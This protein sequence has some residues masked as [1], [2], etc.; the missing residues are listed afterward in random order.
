MYLNDMLTSEQ[1]MDEM[2]KRR[3]PLRIM[4]AENN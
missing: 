3:L 4:R 2:M 1:V